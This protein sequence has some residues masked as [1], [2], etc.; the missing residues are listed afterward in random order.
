MRG[1]ATAGSRRAVFSRMRVV[2]MVPAE[3]TTLWAS[4]VTTVPGAMP[5]PAGVHHGVAVLGPRDGHRHRH[6]GGPDVPAVRGGREED[7]P[8][9]GVGNHAQGVG[10]VGDGGNEQ[11]ACGVPLVV[12]GRRRLELR[13]PVQVVQGR[14]DP[15]RLGAVP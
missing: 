5:S 3:S 15:E 10:G 6:P 14:I 9:V 12:D 7:L 11:L 8:Y 13:E 1:L 4:M 2:P